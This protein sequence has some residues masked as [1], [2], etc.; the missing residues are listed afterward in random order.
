[1]GG[2]VLQKHVTVWEIDTKEDVLASRNSPAG[3]SAV[4][5]HQGRRQATTRS[6]VQCCWVLEGCGCAFDDSLQDASHLVKVTGHEENAASGQGDGKGVF[7]GL[8]LETWW[9]GR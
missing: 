9:W 3:Q 6:D 4:Q 8:V 2:D 7:S 1:M 5:L